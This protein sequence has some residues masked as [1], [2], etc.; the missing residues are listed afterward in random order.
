MAKHHSLYL[1]KMLKKSIFPFFR[2][3][4][5]EAP[6]V[7]LLFIILILI[8]KGYPLPHRDDLLFIGSPIN[9]VQTGHFDNPFC[10]GFTAQFH[11]IRHFAYMPL[12]AFLIAGW[13]EILGVS[14]ESL[15]SFQWLFYF[16]GMAAL[17][18]LCVHKFL[19]RRNAALLLCFVYL[20]IVIQMGLRP[21]ACGFGFVLAGLCWLD[22]KST[23]GKFLGFALCGF[24]FIASLLAFG[25]FLPV[26]LL[27][28]FE[29]KSSSF[30]SYLIASIGGALATIILLGVMINFEFAEFFR[31]INEV[32]KTKGEELSSLFFFFQLLTEKYE[33]VLKLPL[34]LFTVGIGGF[35][36][37]KNRGLERKIIITLMACL[38][39]SA[40][41]YTEKTAYFSGLIISWMIIATGFN[42]ISNRIG[43][44]IYA[45][46]CILLFSITQINF[47]IPLIFQKSSIPP[48]K[49]LV[50]MKTKKFKT[51]VADT[52]ATRYVYDYHLPPNFIG[53]NYYAADFYPKSFADCKNDEI[54]LFSP[55]F[56]YHY[57]E[58]LPKNNIEFV[59]IL[60]KQLR[61][62]P[63]YP[64]KIML[65]NR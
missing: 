39:F 13:L 60:G 32:V 19:L 2:F 62:V 58:E 47:L 54:W 43:Q 42:C 15:L 25:L 64:H 40:L 7:L 29:N 26:A 10:I 46:V 44:N 59:T 14:T 63:I 57:E 31:V 36:I 3:T 35:V 52:E 4:V 37:Y 49:A 51:I 12:Q 18:F 50:E 30:F 6:A 48:S 20:I 9:Y 65:Y 55:G 34:Y 41:L 8:L 38:L 61:S 27:L 16:I 11:T 24:G 21:D 5:K 33:I 17:Y 28:F 56:A 23:W 45:A 53:L 22:S 1:F